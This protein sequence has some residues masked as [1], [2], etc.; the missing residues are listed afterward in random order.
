MKKS[1]LFLLI[2]I[3]TSF[4]LCASFSFAQQSRRK[5]NSN[6]TKSLPKTSV[7]TNTQ[8]NSTSG[9][10]QNGTLT[11]N[12][13]SAKG[14]INEELFTNLYLGNFADIDFDRDD[15]NFG[16]LYEAYLIAYAQRCDSHLPP[17]NRVER[18]YQR[19]N[20]WSVT[21][22]G[23]GM[24]ISS[25]GIGH[26]TV[27]TGL[28]AAPEMYAAKLKLEQIQAGDSLRNV[29]GVFMKPDALAGAMNMVGNAQNMA[30]DMNSLFT[31]NS[32]V[33]PGLKRFQENLRLFAL[34]KQPIRLGATANPTTAAA[35]SP[36]VSYQDQNYSKLVEDLIY[37]QSK[38]WV[39]NRFESGSVSDVSVSSRDNQGRPS[40]ITAHYIYNGFSNRSQGSVTLTFT[41]GLPEC[42]YFFD[43]PATCRTPNRKIVAA[44]ANNTYQK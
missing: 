41:D 15:L 9:G 19:C 14:L 28:F 7:N 39:M 17:R 18:T 6:R 24:E 4:F 26:E 36:G 29:F 31:L 44:F 27:G 10:R 32:C 3:F 16:I 21:R 12:S 23:Y 43:F 30:S 40:K 38:T 25:E 37:E 8:Q 5:T 34:N 1:K 2:S 22:N 20:A 11:P 42:M 33:S 13:F 35:R